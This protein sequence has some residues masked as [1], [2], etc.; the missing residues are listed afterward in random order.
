MLS[1]NR[2]L[3]YDT[4]VHS[5]KGKAN[6]LHPTNH[7]KIQTDQEI[8][9]YIQSYPPTNKRHKELMCVCTPC[10]WKWRARSIRLHYF[11]INRCSLQG[12][13]VGGDGVGRP[14]MIRSKKTQR[15]QQLHTHG[16]QAAFISSREALGGFSF[17]TSKIMEGLAPCGTQ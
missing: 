14:V 10:V 13:S 1:H 15:R 12:A 5:F 6:S 16:T 7:T 2:D 17:A 9:P 4:N 8:T 3:I 11:G